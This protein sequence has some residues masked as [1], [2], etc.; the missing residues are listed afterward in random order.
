[1][2]RALAEA[3][4]ALGRT[5]PNPMV[6][7][8]I[9][10]H[11]RTIAVGHH[12]RAG[13]PHAEIVALTQA[14]KRADGADMYVTL[15]PCSH[16]GRTGPCTD[17]VIAA[18]IKRV[19]VGM[20]DPFRLVN[21]RGIRKLRAAGVDVTVGVLKEACTTLNEAF[22]H[23][24]KYKRPFV[25][26]KIAQSLDGKIATASGQSQWITSAPARRIGH[27]LRNR[28]D[29][30]LVGSNTVR[31][32]DPRLTCRLRHGRDPVRV[33]LDTRASLS[34]SSQV[35]SIAQ[36]S[37][38]PTW[39]CVGKQAPARRCR[40]LERAGARLIVCETHHGHLDLRDV[41]E[42]LHARSIFSVLVEGGPTVLGAFFDA[43]L[44]NQLHAFIAPTIIGGAAAPSAVGGR[45]A[46]ALAVAAR[47][48]H[49]QLQHVGRDIYLRAN[50][51]R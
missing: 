46:A 38:A 7:C 1:M 24:Q 33:I 49:P 50:V 48:E 15:E 5:H 34:P 22:V 26:A 23:V 17:A 21:G 43:G 14:G 25:V 11:G 16:H 31:V 40:A 47:L 8:V 29:A 9:V 27:S 10:R 28:L 45:G 35:F 39:V 30:I 42:H 3:Q 32:D 36:K 20:R 2:E 4:R 44:I 51:L 18:G 12:A 19:F 6:G 41:L 13:L 37:S